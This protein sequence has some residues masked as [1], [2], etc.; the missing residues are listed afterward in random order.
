M[1]I[2][3]VRVRG[4]IAA[5]TALGL[6]AGCDEEGGTGPDAVPATLANH[7]VT[8]TLIKNLVAGATAYS[9]ISSDDV[10]AGSPSFI[11]GGSAD[12]AGLMRNADGTFQMLVNHE[13]NFSVSSVKLDATFKP[14][15]AQ[16]LLNSDA[17]RFRLC[18]ATL[19]TP[20][21]HG[22]GPIFLTNGESGNE[23]MIHALDPVAGPNTSRLLPALGKWTSEQSLPLPK[24]AYPGK[25]V[26]VIGDDDSGVN[27]G[28]LVMYVSNTVGDLDNGN[29]YVLAR[30]DRNVRERDMVVGQSY[31]V[32][33]R[34]LVNQKDMT[35][36]QLDA[37]SATLQ[38]MKFGRTEDVDYRRGTN[39]GRELYFNVTGQNNTGANADFSRTKYGRVY[40]LL[41]DSNDP[42]KGTLSVI[43]DGD[44]DAGPAREFQNPDNI[45][46]TENQV[47]IGEDPNGYGDETHDARIYRYDIATRAFSIVMELDHKRGDAKYNTA[48]PSTFGSWEFGAMVDISDVVDIDDTFLIAIQPHTWNGA[49]YRG[50]DG[51][52]LRANEQQASQMIVVKG[53]PR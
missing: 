49:K 14:V 11:F 36:A 35:G 37:A 30:T 26:I 13:D 17:G 5:L 34:Q 28:Q 1:R 7:S 12:G 2:A 22:F 10:L 21:E 45:T 6:F 25:T 40:R 20:E 23:S 27:G 50:V 32:D 51:G 47:Y 9:L 39:A 33:F 31:P 44:D 38:A 53:L 52:T 15:S 3:S 24:T 42:L 29:L 46:V 19:A 4:T 16:Y 18:S 41:L 43:L 48:G 8:P